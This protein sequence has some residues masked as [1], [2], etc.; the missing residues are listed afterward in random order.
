M[1]SEPA[2]HERYKW[3]GFR[4]NNRSGVGWIAC[5]AAADGLASGLKIWILKT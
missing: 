4:P 1:I 3:Q 2:L 5:L